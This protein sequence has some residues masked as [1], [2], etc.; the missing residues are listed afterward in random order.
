MSGFVISRGSRP[1][2]PVKAVL[3]TLFTSQSAGTLQRFPDVQ[4]IE[5]TTD[6]SRI[7]GVTR[8]QGID[9][10]DRGVRSIL[11]DVS[12]VVSRC[13]PGI[14]PGAEQVGMRA[15][16]PDCTKQGKWLCKPHGNRVIP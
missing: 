13:S 15:M 16:L 5:V 12:L 2:Q 10:I 8:T 3:P 6:D 11:E 9:N 7:K 1:S 4:A 14:T